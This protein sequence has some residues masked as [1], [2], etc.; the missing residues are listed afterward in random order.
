MKLK[1]LS[2]FF[3]AVA[4]AMFTTTIYGIVNN[5]SGIPFWDEWNGYLAFYNRMQNGGLDLLKAFLEQHNEHKILFTRIWFWI[6]F[7]FF[8]GHL[9]FQLIVNVCLQIISLSI[10]SY[11]IWKQDIEKHLKYI[12]GSIVVILGFT[13]MQSN[14][15]TWGFQS[16]FFGVYTN[17]LILFFS[18]YTWAFSQQKKY[19]YLSLL[20]A[21]LTCF[22]LANGLLALVI[23]CLF[24]L[25]YSGNKKTTIVFI[26]FS[27]FCIILY[28]WNFHQV[29]GHS[30]ISDSIK[31]HPIEV[32][33]YVVRF[34]GGP[35]H[36]VFNSKLEIID[37]FGIIFLILSGTACLMFFR[38]KEKYPYTIILLLLIAFVV[39]TAF[40]TATGRIKF[41]IDS[42]TASRYQTPVLFGWISLVV[43]Y[44]IYNNAN[45]RIAIISIFLFMTPAIL[46]QQNVF[47]NKSESIFNQKKEFLAF[48]MGVQSPTFLTTLYPAF[49]DTI[50][51]LPQIKNNIYPFNLHHAQVWDSSVLEG[52]IDEIKNDTFLKTYVIRGWGGSK[53]NKKS[54]ALIAFKNR[55]N[56]IVG[57]AVCGLRRDD[58]KNAMGYGDYA[59][60]EGFIRDTVNLKTN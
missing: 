56:Q 39:L 18:I 45:V 36:H 17:A 24:M 9:W 57:Y 49:K 41:G 19:F 14:N 53:Q 47:G 31:N 42:A 21:F 40:I 51:F 35:I 34:F 55:A 37:A 44:F 43:F 60:F 6:G 10:I 32:I 29:N 15:F 52:Y 11:I 5:Y 46:L 12:L 58:V 2:Y 48:R 38:H 59:G 27:I 13:W 28:L 20:F 22:T 26:S 1:Y 8:K 25:F 3:I 30:S 23:S 7:T 50:E 33:H 4:V 16:Q 54:P